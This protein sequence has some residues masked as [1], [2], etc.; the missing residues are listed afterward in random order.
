M[1]SMTVPPRHPGP[2]A[3]YVLA[4]AADI[5]PK[6]AGLSWEPTAARPIAVEAADRVL[7]LLEVT[8]GETLLIHGA[9]AP[10]ARCG[11]LG[12]RRAE[13]NHWATTASTSSRVEGF[14][15]R[16]G[17]AA[18]CHDVADDQYRE[19][20]LFG[21][22]GGECEDSAASEAEP[23]DVGRQLRDELAETIDSI[24]SRAAMV[25]GLPPAERTRREDPGQ[26]DA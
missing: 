4:K 19:G 10:R 17:D 25:V 5:A 13:P 14:A 24:R 21:P 23:V 26:P 12:R 8:A 9:A 11:N 22:N 1:A 3:Q 16:R 7:G 6:P 15:E 2:G 18:R 20:H